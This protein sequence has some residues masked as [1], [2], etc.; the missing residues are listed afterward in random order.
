MHNFSTQSVVVC[1]GGRDFCDSSEDIACHEFWE[2][3]LDDELLYLNDCSHIQ[4]AQ[5]C[6]KM[7]GIYEGKLGTK[8]FVPEE[9]GELNAHIF[10]VQETFNSIGPVFPHVRAMHVMME[11]P[12]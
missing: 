8:S 10:S 6:V 9:I 4:N 5:Y 1:L 12:L 2:A 11:N 7:T 3:D